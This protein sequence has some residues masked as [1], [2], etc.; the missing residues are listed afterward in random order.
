MQFRIIAIIFSIFLLTGCSGTGSD[1]RLAHVAGIVSDEPEKAMAM[2]D[3]IGQDGLSEGDRHFYDLLSVK[4]RDKAYVRH[5]SDSLILDVIEY[6]SSHRSDGLYPEA[7]YYGGRVYSDLGDLP[8]ALRYF[9]DA[10]D[11]LPENSGDYDLRSRILSQTGRLLNKL[12]LY[13]DAIPY[14]EGSLEISRNVNDTLSEVYDM[15][16]LGRVYIKAHDLVRADSCFRYALWKSRNM[17]ASYMAKSSMYIADVKYRLGQ[18]DSA[19]IYVRHTPDMVRPISRNTALAI[20]ADSYY[21]AG[22]L[23]TAY[24]YA[25]ELVCSADSTNKRTGYWLLLT[26]ELRGRTHLDSLSRYLSEYLLL[27]ESY[28]NENEHRQAIMQNTLYNYQVHE[29]ERHKAEESRKEMIIWFCISLLFILLLIIGFL[30][31]HVRSK[32]VAIELHETMA[33]LEAVQKAIGKGVVEGGDTSEVID[34]IS[35]DPGSLRSRLR[36]TIALIDSDVHERPSLPS[37]LIDSE[38]YRTLQEYIRE[39]KIIMDKDPLWNDLYSTI[40]KCNPDFSIKLQ[41]LMGRG[42]KR[43]EQQ[44]IT[45]IKYGV[46]PVQMTGLL[47][48]SKGCISSRREAL[49]TRLLGEKVNQKA[50]D[51]IICSL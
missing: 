11:A 4:A 12:R 16:L 9:Q 24:M 13:D 45:L 47:G 51:T 2:L 46:T 29:K 44:T 40:L 22:I 33:R 50:I 36:E 49:C 3:S 28:F 14:I 48:K 26:P 1:A 39:G 20:A 5:T 38:C 18:I 35:P 17:P 21:A 15:Q 30:I 37:G 23:D 25:H 8:S 31:Y 7:L 41:K 34:P 19:L 32:Q 6:Y 43:H 27:Q 42:L 10:L